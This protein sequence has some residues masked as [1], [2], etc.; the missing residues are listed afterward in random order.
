VVASA[1]GTVGAHLPSGAHPAGQSMPK[2]CQT[3]DARHPGPPVG[4]THF[5][6]ALGVRTVFHQKQDV[7]HVQPREE[8]VTLFAGNRVF[9]EGE[10]FL[11]VGPGG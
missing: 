10:A 3:W 1:N 8:C 7:P 6:S 5:D 4:V 11:G 9:P 2:E